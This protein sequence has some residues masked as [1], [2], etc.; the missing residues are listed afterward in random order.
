M[1]LECFVVQDGF[2]G[3]E[4]GDRA[5]SLNAKCRGE[6]WDGVAACAQMDVNEVD[7]GVLDLMAEKS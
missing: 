5:G 2:V 4:D 7:A 1:L 6:I 3:R